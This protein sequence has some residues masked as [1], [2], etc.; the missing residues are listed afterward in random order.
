MKLLL[1]FLLGFSFTYAT[2]LL[3]LLSQLFEAKMALKMTKI[4][5]QIGEWSHQ[6]GF[7]DTYRMDIISSSE[8]GDDYCDDEEC[9]N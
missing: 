5:N 2:N 6:E 7:N 3:D 4:N 9:D 1:F 8:Y